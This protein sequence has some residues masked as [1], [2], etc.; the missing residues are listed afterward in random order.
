MGVDLTLI[1]I[2]IFFVIQTSTKNDQTDN[3]AGDD[4]TFI[5]HRG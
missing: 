3:S 5:R 2:Y 4:R 1:I